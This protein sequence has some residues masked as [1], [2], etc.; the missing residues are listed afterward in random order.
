MFSYFFSQKNNHSQLLREPEIV[1]T[2][3]KSDNFKNMQALRNNGIG[4]HEHCYI[5]MNKLEHAVTL[6][7]MLVALEA[8]NI[9]PDHDIASKI[10]NKL[11]GTLFYAGHF[12]STLL[13]F[14]YN[15]NNLRY[16]T[17]EQTRSLSISQ[18][19]NISPKSMCR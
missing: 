12:T 19:Q 16:A 5:M 7:D 1:D 14:C 13:N 6:Q 2:L 18:Q 11:M 10:G 3:K 9:F 17:L 4:L 8:I 15:A